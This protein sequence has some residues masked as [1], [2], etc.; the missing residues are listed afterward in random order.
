MCKLSFFAHSV[1]TS[2]ATWK[3]D[4]KIYQKMQ[5]ANEWI[6]MF[7]NNDPGVIFGAQVIR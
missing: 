4:P 3:C 2:D 6:K 7:E 1:T 5:Y